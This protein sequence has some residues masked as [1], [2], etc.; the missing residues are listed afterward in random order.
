MI[1]NILLYNRKT[2]KGIEP[3]YYQYNDGIDYDSLD[4]G[5]KKFFRI[6]FLGYEYDFANYHAK[7]KNYDGSFLPKLRKAVISIPWDKL[8]PDLQSETIPLETFQDLCHNMKGL[9]YEGAYNFNK[10]TPFTTY[11]KEVSP[12]EFELTAVGAV[13]SVI[14]PG[15][16]TYS[17]LAK[18]Q[19]VFGFYIRTVTRTP[20]MVV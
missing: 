19:T 14:K 12:G 5:T 11:Y 8:N 16:E 18:Y 10:I 2:E 13:P 15:T 4:Y 3:V 9:L 20:F 17:K 7:N 6:V 1:Q